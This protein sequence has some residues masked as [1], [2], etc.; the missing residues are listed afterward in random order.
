[1]S[2]PITSNDGA[3]HLAHDSR[4]GLMVAGVGTVVLDALVDGSITTLT[5]L[6]TSGWGGWWT[7][8]AS[9]AVATALGVLTA[10]RAKRHKTRE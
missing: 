4:L 3:N 2:E 6:D 7:T 10:Y 5:N 1:M 9:A 8:V